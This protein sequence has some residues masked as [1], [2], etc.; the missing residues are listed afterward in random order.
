M[1]I[2]VYMYIVVYKYMKYKNVYI[3]SLR[4]ERGYEVL[5]RSPCGP[6]RG[7]SGVPRGPYGSLRG[8]E[9]PIRG[10]YG[11][12]DAFIKQGCGLPG[13]ALKAPPR[14]RES[15]KAL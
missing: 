12:F 4:F 5:K 9:K 10:P 7:P 13:D 15:L 2:G 6:L 1:Y 3:N 8:P 11:R 14:P